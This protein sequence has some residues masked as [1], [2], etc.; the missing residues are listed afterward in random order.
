MVQV[1][2]DSLGQDRPVTMS[3]RSHAP[4]ATLDTVCHMRHGSDRTI[5]LAVTAASLALVLSAC[6]SSPKP[7]A[8]HRPHRS[9]SAG[10]SSTGTPSGAPT[11]ASPSASESSAAPASSLSFSPRSGGKHLDECQRLVPGDDPAEFLYFPVLV[12]A[13]TTAQLASLTTAHSTGV[14]DAGAWVA[15]AATTPQ[16]GTF[17]GWPPSTLLTHSAQ[18]QWSKRVT[19][20]GATLAAGS[21]YNV[22]LR[23]QVDPTPGDSMVK[24]IVF[25]YADA[26]GDHEVTWKATTTFSMSC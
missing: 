26:T 9:T 13:A 7:T 25:R 5:L 12:K 1:T 18:L 19:A 4:L 10:P 20:G 24:G 21:W 14:V 15:P 8:S 16:T 3:S 11:S 2:T 22:F 17:K 23:L 6:S